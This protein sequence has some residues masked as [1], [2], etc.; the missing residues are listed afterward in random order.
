M[1]ALPHSITPSHLG[2]PRG[3]AVGVSGSSL[4]FPRRFFGDKQG[5]SHMAQNR[6]VGSQEINRAPDLAGLRLAE[7]GSS[8]GEDEPW[9]C[10]LALLGGR[11]GRQSSSEWEWVGKQGW[12]LP[13]GSSDGE[14]PDCKAE[15]SSWS[16][17]APRGCSKHPAPTGTMPVVLSTDCG[18]EAVVPSSQLRIWHFKLLPKCNSEVF[19]TLQKFSKSEESR[20]HHPWGAALGNLRRGCS[21]S[22]DSCGVAGS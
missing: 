21:F 8:G 19:P 3:A 16:C 5:P 18:R 14:G 7:G 2:T 4:P 20:K 15:D 9:W 1:S 11:R 6:C 10:P 17:R 12:N 22:K 13:Q